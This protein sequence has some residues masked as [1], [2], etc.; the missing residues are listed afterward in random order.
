[1]HKHF[2]IEFS[3]DKKTKFTF[4]D[5]HIGHEWKLLITN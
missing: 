3:D 2:E 5:D 1:M 4:K